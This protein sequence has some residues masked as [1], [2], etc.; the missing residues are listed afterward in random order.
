M[1]LEGRK[2]TSAKSLNCSDDLTNV[3]MPL[4]KRHPT[5]S[6]LTSRERASRLP[7]Q[8][9]L[10]RRLFGSSPHSLLHR[11]SRA[12]LARARLGHHHHDVGC[13][14][15]LANEEPPCDSQTCLPLSGS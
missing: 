10:L 9:P 3:E 12:T 13:S 2:E 14:V 4:F 11:A 15:P 1:M 6:P 7:P 5:F 8:L